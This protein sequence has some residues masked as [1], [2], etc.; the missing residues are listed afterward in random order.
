MTCELVLRLADL[1]SEMN[2][3]SGN[4]VD[5][6]VETCQEKLVIPPSFVHLYRIPQYERPIC[7]AA[8]RH[9]PRFLVSNRMVSV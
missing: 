8:T 5:S 9:F 3:R 6:W 4:T 2:E 7:N 1:V